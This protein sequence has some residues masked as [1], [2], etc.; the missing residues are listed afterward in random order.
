MGLCTAGTESAAAVAAK[1]AVNRRAHV[2]CQ[3]AKA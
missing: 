1:T 2:A 3:T